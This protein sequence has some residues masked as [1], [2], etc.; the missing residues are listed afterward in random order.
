MLT[1]KTSRRAFAAALGVS[2]LALAPAATAQDHTPPAHGAGP[3]PEQM[4]ELHAQLETLLTLVYAH[5]DFDAVEAHLTG[6][7]RDNPERFGE[8]AEA[9]AA[10]V[11]AFVQRVSEQAAADPAVAAEHTA[12]MLI[13]AHRR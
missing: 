3:G 12:T 4:A 2:A 10:H 13:D 9:F 8:N 5:A 6:V 11:S 7:I 1:F